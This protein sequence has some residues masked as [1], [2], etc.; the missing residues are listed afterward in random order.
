MRRSN[1]TIIW[2]GLENRGNQHYWN[3]EMDHFKLTL[4][5]SSFVIPLILSMTLFAG[6]GKNLPKQVMAFALLNAFFVFLGNYFYFQKLYTVY[7]CGHSFHIATVLWIFPSIYLYIKAIISD[8]KQFRKELIHL[9]PGL[10]FGLISAVLFYGFLNQEERTYYLTNYRTGVEFSS[11][12][13]KA[14]S[15]FRVID[16]MLIVLQVVYYSFTLVRASVQYEDKLNEEFS[17]IENFSIRWIRWFNVSL[18]LVG[19]LSIAFYMFN[20]FKSSNELFLVFFLFTISAFI[21]VVGIWSFKQEKP[22]ID[23]QASYFV[24]NP[25]SAKIPKDELA[26]KLVKYFEDENPYLQPDLNLTMVCKKIGTNRTYLSTIINT[27]FGMNFNTFVNVYRTRYI[28]DYLKKHPQTTKEELVQIGGF[29]S[30]SSLKRALNKSV[31]G[32]QP[33]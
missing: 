13:L 22:E 11:F 10:L 18:V 23:W 4:L 33:K 7:S 12:N 25:K 5:I 19:F 17:N 24:P 30:I 27:S 1:R 21:W 26:Q 32:S 20:P 16:V 3:F 31:M 9:I 14:V 8:E 6:S 15:V 29:G 28:N 2:R